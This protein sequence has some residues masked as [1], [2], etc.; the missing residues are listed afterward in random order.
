MTT[1]EPMRDRID[2]LS[3]GIDPI[4]S[5]ASATDNNRSTLIKRMVVEDVLGGMNTNNS[6]A[7]GS[8]LDLKL[9]S[10]KR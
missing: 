9:A 7:H 8:A 5:F 3:S 1:V 6:N 10:H 4:V 2:A